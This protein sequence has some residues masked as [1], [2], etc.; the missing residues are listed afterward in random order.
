MRCSDFLELYSD[1]RDGLIADRARTERIRHHLATC[2]RCMEYDARISRG[3]MALR[4]TSDIEP[5]RNFLCQLDD[6]LAGS[7]QLVPSDGAARVAPAGFMVG[8]ML[9][10]ALAI[11]VSRARP[12][13]HSVATPAT[14]LV[15]PPPF[16]VDGAWY[17]GPGLV[18][19]P[20]LQR[21]PTVVTH[22]TGESFG[23]WLALSR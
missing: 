9:L 2:S 5:S 18:A 7:P 11:V 12:A 15:A 8:L 10:A 1:Y 17:Q 13:T 23:T 21:I 19:L 14:T 16:T 6:R 20:T 22:P 4:A 3:V